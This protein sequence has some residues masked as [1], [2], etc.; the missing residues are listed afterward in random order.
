MNL[1][2]VPELP[3][4][5]PFNKFRF[6]IQIGERKQTKSTD[7]MILFYNKYITD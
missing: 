3:Y 4:N 1:V 5:T 6:K 7:N 2:H